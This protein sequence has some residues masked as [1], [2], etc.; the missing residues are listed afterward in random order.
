MVRQ[1][2]RALPDHA[3]AQAEYRGATHSAISLRLRK[4]IGNNKDSVKLLRTNYQRLV[5]EH[6]LAQ[7]SYNGEMVLRNTLARW[8]INTVPEGTLA[9]RAAT[10]LRRAFVLTSP[11]LAG[12]L[13]RSWLNGWCTGR[14]YQVRTG[15]CLLGCTNDTQ[16]CQDSIEHYAHCI[17]VSNFGMETLHLPSHMVGTVQ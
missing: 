12:V 4:S 5:V 13:F 1:L 9:R 15:R 11:R 8:H 7:D 16:E 10:I 17:V 2:L 6:L 14:R 3:L